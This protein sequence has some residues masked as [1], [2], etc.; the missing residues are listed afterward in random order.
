MTSHA[1]IV[2]DPLSQIQLDDTFS[3]K[4]WL[5]NSNKNDAYDAFKSNKLWNDK[6]YFRKCRNDLIK[7]RIAVLLGQNNDTEIIESLIKERKT[8]ATTKLCDSCLSENKLLARFCQHCEKTSFSHREFYIENKFGTSSINDVLTDVKVKENEAKIKCGEPDIKNPNSYENVS[9]ILRNIGFRAGIYKYDNNKSRKWLFLEVDGTIYVIVEQLINNTYHCTQCKCSFFGKKTFEE[10][11]CSNL[12]Y[13]HEFDW[14]ILF[15]GLLHIEM[16]ICRAF[17]KLNWEVF[18]KDVAYQMGFKSPAAQNYAYKCSDHHKTWHMLETVPFAFTDELLHP[19]VNFCKENNEAA[20][21][22]GYWTWNEAV[23]NENCIYLQ[24]MIFTYLLAIMLYRR[25]Q[26]MNDAKA[27]MV[28][29]RKFMPMFYARNHPLYQKIMMTSFKT[30]AIIPEEIREVVMNH[31]TVSNTGNV[32]NYQGGD[33][34]LEEINKKVK[35]LPGFY[36]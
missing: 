15:P 28:G 36:L 14:V 5:L 33:A 8:K 7:K 19:Y 9:S 29:Q 30:H 35:T 26:R 34:C 13:E 17:V 23:V 31:L 12:R 6:I 4:K 16:N 18:M 32:G 22:E 24:N 25:G 10:H 20:T 2:I 27:I 11:G 1:Y 21:V 3:P